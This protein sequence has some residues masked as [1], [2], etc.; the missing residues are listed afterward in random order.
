[1]NVIIFLTR[2]PWVYKTELYSTPTKHKL[3]LTDQWP[4]ALMTPGARPHITRVCCL[5]AGNTIRGGTN[6]CQ[7]L[8]C[9]KV[10]TVQLYLSW[11]EMVQYLHGIVFKPRDS[12]LNFKG[13]MILIQNEIINGALSGLWLVSAYNITSGWHFH[14]YSWSLD[15]CTVPRECKSAPDCEWD[16]FVFCPAAARDQIAR[17][18]K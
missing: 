8:V 7:K 1:M 9:S 6:V 5:S 13:I 14:Y 10:I 2:E 18:N 15:Y 4:L 3:L 12:M 11:N 17:I 16:Y